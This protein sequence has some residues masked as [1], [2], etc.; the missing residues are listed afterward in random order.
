MRAD[1][2][3]W[4]SHLLSFLYLKSTFFPIT[5]PSPSWVS[6]SKIHIP[7]IDLSQEIFRKYSKTNI[8]H[9]F[10]RTVET[11]VGRRKEV[12]KSPS[13]ERTGLGINVSINC[14]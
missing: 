1:G 4:P 6:I 14:L 5:Y 2:P 10:L 11:G 12:E 7:N 13:G 9:T 3:W 8:P